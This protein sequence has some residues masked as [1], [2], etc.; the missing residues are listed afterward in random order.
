M[1]VVGITGGIGSGKS[2]VCQVFSTLKIPVYSSDDESKNI[3]QNDPEIQRNLTALLGPEIY[4][5]GILNRALMAEKI[6]R[7]ETLLDS[8]NKIIHPKVA[9]DFKLWLNRHAHKAY[10]IQESAILFESNAY[11]FCDIKVTVS[12]SEKLRISRVIQRKNMTMEKLKAIMQHQIPESEKV[13]RSDYVIENNESKL[14]IPQ[15]LQLHQTF[16]NYKAI[17]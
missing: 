14:L 8:V 2:L 12:S 6:F 16:I 3:S 7:D 9:A 10:V 17:S 11:L 13:N 4:Q 5:H 15:I 1:I